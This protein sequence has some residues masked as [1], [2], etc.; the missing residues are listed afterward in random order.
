MNKTRRQKVDEALGKLQEALD[1]LYYVQEEEQTAFDNMPEHLQ[2][3]RKGLEMEDGIVY[4][5][6]AVDE[7]NDTMETL[8]S[9]IS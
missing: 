4:L 3:S 8:K 9:W 7:I 2:E 5:S 1:I 6:D